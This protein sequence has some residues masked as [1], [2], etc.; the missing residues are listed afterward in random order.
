M[1]KKSQTNYPVVIFA[2]LLA[3]LAFLFF[4][5]YLNQDIPFSSFSFAKTG[6]IFNSLVYAGIIFGIFIVIKKNKSVINKKSLIAFI[7][8]SWVLLISSFITTK[9]K[10]VSAN[11]YILNQ[12]G[13]KVLTGLLFLLFLLTLLYYLI[14]L[15]RRIIG[16][17]KSTIVKNV[18]ST[19]LILVL[20]IILI[21]I[22]IDNISYTSGRWTINKSEKNIAVVLG[23]AVWSG[24][25]PSP[26]LSS[27]VDKA[28]ELL[29]Q[30]FVG[31]IVLTGGKAPGEL[32]E[33]QVAYEYARVKGVD[34]SKVIIETS[35]SS[36]ADQIK[37]IKNNLITNGK[38]SADIILISDAYHLPRAIE[39]S[40]FF[41]LDV[42]V[43]ESDHKLDF[44][45]KFY[46]KLRESIALFNFWNF[47][48]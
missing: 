36:T 40:K 18:F 33:S 5:K 26:T 9:L 30:G 19:V 11:V 14:F 34:T 2:L 47:A 31:K 23:A 32:P 44:K 37:W 43:A 38:S 39:I 12:P 16:K 22:Y 7:V 24:N 45:D 3:Q 41:N 15:W 21:I 1:P 35:T 20:F 27:R 17:N 6:N 13:D 46:N 42:K 48:L 28:L 8:I 10:I 29:E 4:V 25:I